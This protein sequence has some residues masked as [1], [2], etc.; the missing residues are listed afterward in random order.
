MK[1]KV[2]KIVSIGSI[3]EYKRLKKIDENCKIDEDTKNYYSKGKI[4]CLKLI[5]K[6]YK[7]NFTHLR[8]PNVYGFK[9]NKNFLI[10]NIFIQ[11][12]S[13]KKIFLSNLNQ[14]RIYIFVDNLIDAI[15]KILDQNLKGVINVGQGNSIPAYQF[16][17]TYYEILNPKNKNKLKI[18]NIK[19]NK[20]FFFTSIYFKEKNYKLHLKENL[21]KI[22]KLQKKYFRNI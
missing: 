17:K 13:Y 10:N 9:Q 14:E 8:I 20:K 6:F 22:I 5:K 15:F 2:E 3:D 19:K 7:K 16:A 18:L 12:K 1:A 11:N 4:R 21:K